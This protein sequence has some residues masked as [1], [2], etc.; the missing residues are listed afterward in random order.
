MM[1]E[2]NGTSLMV[3]NVINLPKEDFWGIKAP[4][5][6]LFIQNKLLQQNEIFQRKKNNERFGSM[7]D[8]CF[9]N[10]WP[11]ARQSPQTVSN[12]AVCFAK[13]KHDTLNILIHSDLL[14]F[15]RGGILI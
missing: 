1:N 12:G 9:A 5:Y 6:P 15:Q 8:Q 4:H 7:F 13:C 14:A 3:T 2:K 11:K 10:V